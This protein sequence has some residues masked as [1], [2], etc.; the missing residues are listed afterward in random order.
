MALALGKRLL[1]IT[2]ERIGD[3]IFCTPAIALLKQQLP[4]ATLTILAPSPAAASVFAHNPAI[5]YIYTAPDKKTLKRLAQEHDSVIDLHNNKI[6]RYYSDALRLPVQRS[7]RT[8]PNQH[9]S[10]VAS[11]FIAGLLNCAA[12][13]PT[14]YLLYPQP[15]HFKKIEQLFQAADVD[16]HHDVLIGCHMGCSQITRKGWKFWKKTAGHKSWPIEN[17]KQLEE[18][19]RRD[20]HNVRFVLTGSKN[21][22]HLCQQLTAHSERAIDLSGQTSVLELSAL[23]HY[24]HLFLTG[25]TGPLHIASTTH[26]PIVTLFGSTSPTE[27]GPYPLKPQHKI[28][29]ATIIEG[30]S[31]NEVYSS[32]KETLRELS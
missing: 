5:Q 15:E 7:P 6:T 3:V 27:T 32:I 20:N 31:V 21:E 30:I 19:L 17:F 12:P 8:K 14:D 4:D 11:E 18:Q 26:K 10:A 25:D 28:I 16:L 24:L 2:S 22:S 1:L 23:M 9:Q 13:A 29:Q